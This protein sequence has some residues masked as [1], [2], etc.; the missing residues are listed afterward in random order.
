MSPFVTCPSFSLHFVGD[1]LGKAYSDKRCAVGFTSPHSL[2]HTQL[3]KCLNDQDVRCFGRE[4]PLSNG[5]YMTIDEVRDACNSNFSSLFLDRHNVFCYLCDHGP[6]TECV[7]NIAPK[8]W[9][10][11][12]FTILLGDVFLEENTTDRKA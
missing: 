10:G 4:K 9:D 8:L 1:M 2:K 7:E 5:L 12:Y 6:M 3:P 11:S